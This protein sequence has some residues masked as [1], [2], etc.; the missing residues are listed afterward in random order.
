MI[1]GKNQK[2]PQPQEE[3]CTRQFF[4]AKM[5]C[6]KIQVTHLSIGMNILN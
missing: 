3:K 4:L 6:N 2:H 1:A 5:T